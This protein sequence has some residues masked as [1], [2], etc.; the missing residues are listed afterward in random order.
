MS[1]SLRFDIRTLRCRECMHQPVWISPFQELPRMRMP[2][3][4]TLQRHCFEPHDK[5]WCQ[6]RYTRNVLIR[7]LHDSQ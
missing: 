3:L 1:K 5:I 2:C 7:A 4:S 6:V